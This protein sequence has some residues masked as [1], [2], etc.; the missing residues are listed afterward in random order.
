MKNLESA[1]ALLS[2]PI[3]LDTLE[4]LNTLCEQ[5]RGEEAERIAD[6]IEAAVCDAPLDV[7]EAYQRKQL[8]DIQGS[9]E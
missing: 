3:T 6:L 2:K 5:S 9:D 7:L 4:T 8:Q 1:T